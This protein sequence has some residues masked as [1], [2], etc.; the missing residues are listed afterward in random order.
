LAWNSTKHGSSLQK[1]TFVVTKPI[2]HSSHQNTTCVVCPHLWL[3]VQRQSLPTSRVLCERVCVCV[4][5][6][7]RVCVCVCVCVCVFA[8]AHVRMRMHAYVGM[9]FKNG[10][11]GFHFYYISLFG[12]GVVPTWHGTHAEVE[13]NWQVYLLPFHHVDPKDQTQVVRTDWLQMLL[14]T[15]PPHWSKVFI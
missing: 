13:K 14:S 2:H 15:E 4:C 1:I 9:Y 5:V 3:G 12:E 6:C 10:N 7:V 8:H 11:K